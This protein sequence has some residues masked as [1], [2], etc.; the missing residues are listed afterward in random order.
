MMPHNTTE[1]KLFEQELQKISLDALRCYLQEHEWELRMQNDTRFELYINA[2]EVMV[3][4]PITRTLSDYAH[5]LADALS[6][7]ATAQHIWTPR[8]VLELQAHA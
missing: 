8:L 3:L 6:T 7:I 1:W 2:Q 4:L 5:R